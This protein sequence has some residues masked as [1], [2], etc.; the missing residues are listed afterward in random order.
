[1]INMSSIEDYL[2]EDVP[3]HKS[4]L[5]FLYYEDSEYQQF[6]QKKNDYDNSKPY[7]HEHSVQDDYFKILS[8]LYELM[9]RASGFDELFEK[10]KV[11]GYSDLSNSVK[12]YSSEY[13]QCSFESVAKQYLESG[14]KELFDYLKKQGRNF[15][16]IK[17]ISKKELGKNNV[18]GLYIKGNDANL[19]GSYDFEE[20]VSKLAK[21]YGVSKNAATEYVLAHELV[22]ASQKGKNYNTVQ[23]ELDVEKTLSNYFASKGKNDLAY[24]ANDR[25]RNVL[26]N[27]STIDNKVSGSNYSGNSNIMKSSNYSGNSSIMKGSNYSDNSGIMKGSNYFGNSGL[28]KGPGYS[29]S[30]SG[31]GSSYSSAA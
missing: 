3:R 2:K 30:V 6:K 12:D 31:K 27:Y 23:A 19:V 11:K 18:A 1:M 5:D 20:K 7:E 10:P 9:R 25:A 17:E 16:N 14:G 24:I 13:K 15:Y 28:A 26:S 22:H 21:Q 29:R 8:R 4:P